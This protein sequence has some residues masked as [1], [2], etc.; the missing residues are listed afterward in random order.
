MSTKT[1]ALLSLTRSAF[2]LS[3]FIPEN[4]CSLART[5]APRL[6]LGALLA[7]CSHV[8]SATSDI[9]FEFIDKVHPIELNCLYIRKDT[10]DYFVWTN[11][12]NQDKIYTVNPKA[13]SKPKTLI[14]ISKV[15]TTGTFRYNGMKNMY[16]T[17]T[18]FS[19]S[20]KACMICKETSKTSI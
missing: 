5:V 2:F 6:T 12:R 13:S 8:C 18:N 16:Y 7:F 1:W 9:Q 4:C 3:L 15:F 20:Y 10:I 19:C 11:R 14:T 17:R